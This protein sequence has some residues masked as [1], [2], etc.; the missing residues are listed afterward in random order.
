MRQPFS[1]RLRLSVGVA[2]ALGLSLS[3]FSLI[4]YAT[5]GHAL[6][7]QFDE[8]LAQDARAVANMV[9]E[10]AET[11]WEF[12]P[13]ALEDFGKQGGAVYFEIW[14]DDGK[15]LARSPALGERDLARPRGHT[16]PSVVDISLP[17]GGKGRLLLASLPPR[18]DEEGPSQPSGRMLLIAVGRSTDEVDATLA[19]LR[20][21][22]WASGLLVL[23]MAVLIGALA[24]RGGLSPLVRLATCIHGMDARHLGERFPVAELP[25]ELRP[26]VLKLNELLARIEESFQRER[27]F[28]T[29]VS[30]ELRTPL[31]GLRGLLEVSSLRE[32]P[33]TEYRAAI[34]ESLPIVLQMTAL[35][36]NLLMLA[37]L[38]SNQLRIDVEE[39]A[40]RELVEECFGRFSAKAQVRQLRFENIVPAGISI[41]SD[42]EKLRVV[43]SNLLSNAVEYTAEQGT[44]TVEVGK[45]PADVLAICNSGPAIPEA[46]LEKIFTRLY[47]LDP[48]RRDTSEHFG[49]GLPL[50]RSLCHALGLRIV[51]ENRGN[52]QV[53]FQIRRA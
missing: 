15:V 52:G 37:R 29:D 14:M 35:V 3:A 1:L 31:A 10:R 20:M 41:T 25:R 5:F 4:L 11:P 2:V 48:S 34:E 50:A 28:S 7:Q 40:L 12:E 51:A 24:I 53:V 45:H 49:L 38:E 43:I 30:H 46:A 17:N 8:R 36:E 47:R 16:V 18:Q 22:L 33:A 42:R 21:L 13:A 6:W 26:M 27:Q 23:G 44:L 39:I 32:R 9:E 19:A